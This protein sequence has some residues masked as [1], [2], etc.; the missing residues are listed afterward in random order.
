MIIGYAR[1]STNGQILDRQI[2]SLNKAG[3]EQIFQEKYTGTKAD[4]PQL[5][6]MLKIARKGDSIVVADL[7]RLSRSTKDLISISEMLKDK[8][9]ELVS[10]KEK[11]DTSTAT[12]KLMFGMMAIMAQF[13][14][15]IISE[16]TTEGL[17]AARARGRV[18]GRPSKLDETKIATIKQLYNKRELTVKEICAMFDISRPTL[19]KVIE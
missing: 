12:G 13:E 6:E 11:I 10:L 3:V 4:R 7:T 18:G 16:R 15:D 2:D 17:V 19:Y 14:R 8:G 5:N 9:I 1:V